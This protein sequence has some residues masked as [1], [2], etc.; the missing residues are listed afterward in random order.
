MLNFYCDLNN[1][2]KESDEAWVE[3]QGLAEDVYEPD[4]D[5]V[6]FKSK[7]YDPPQGETKTAV[8]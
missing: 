4:A 8:K 7:L 2:R 3:D 5:Q 1:A 6:K